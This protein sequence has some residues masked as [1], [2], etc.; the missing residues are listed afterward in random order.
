MLAAGLYVY[1]LDQVARTGFEGRRWSEPARVY[2]APL[3]LS[4][5]RRLTASALEAHLRAL[6]YARLTRPDR[7]GSFSHSQ[8]RFLIHTR[9]FALPRSPLAA[10]RLELEIR[11]GRIEVLKRD[12]RN[13]REARLDPL[14][15]ARIHPRY[16]QDRILLPRRA[17]PRLLV[18]TLLATEDRHFYHHHG[19]DP[20]GILRA[21]WRNLRAGRVVQGGSTLTQQLVK[22]FYLDRR[23]S[24]WR[25][26]NEALMAILVEFHYSKDAILEAYAN[27]IYLGQDGNRAIHGF[28]LASRFYF[29]RPLKELDL[30]R[31]ALLVGL[32]RG[33]SYYNPWRH[34][35]RA[36]ARRDRVLDILKRLRLASPALVARAQAAPLGV[37]AKGRV[38]AGRYPSFMHLVRRQLQRD[39]PRERLADGGLRVFTSLDPLAQAAAEAAVRD[40][41]PRLERR[42]RRR[43][44]EAALVMADPGSGE[45][46]ALVGGRRSAYAGFDRALD[47]RRPIGSLVKPWVYLTALEDSGRY[48]LTTPL[49]DLPVTRRGA[50]GRIW[51]PGNF[52]GRSHGRVPLYQALVHSYN[53]ASVRLGLDLGVERVARR[54]A[55]LGLERP[56]PRVPA[57]FLGALALSPLEVAGLYQPLADGG[58]RRP[59]HAV[60][61]VADGRGRVLKRYAPEA[62]RVA[63]P[64]AV[65]LLR[66]A[67]ERVVTEGTGRGLGAI[68][69]KGYRVAG[70]T[71]TTD[72]LRDSWFAGFS[73]ERVLVAWVGRDDNRP[74]GLTGSQ[75]ALR[76]WGAVMARQGG[77][78]LGARPPR[79]VVVRWVDPRRDRTTGPACPG[80]LAIPFLDGGTPPPASCG[81]ASP[82]ARKGPQRR[83]SGVELLEWLTD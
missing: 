21:L 54:L 57:L 17:L 53:L 10:W 22:N 13:T 26:V 12:G 71:G 23:R 75:G 63:D 56:V 11:G 61:L 24:L 82:A 79:G 41:L 76:L 74:A 64:R 45:V 58:R 49:E 50:N 32:V 60:R 78:G 46:V 44:L 40:G 28:G 66:W 8:G 18:A 5:G 62:E 6:G 4:P 2:A 55:G 42:H 69:P 43:G 7:P 1:Y 20:G 81:G 37:V 70:K 51:R 30:P 3:V 48:R 59:L 38:A 19:V 73:G 31:V 65:Y 16:D 39:Y 9:A 35:A 14:E 36:R 47:A 15:I 77:R 67:L 80:A 68:L 25:K 83:R 72:D 52:D 34:P 29:N 27:E 33:P